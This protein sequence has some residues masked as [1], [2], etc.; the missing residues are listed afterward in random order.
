MEI[1]AFIVL[2]IFAGLAAG[3]LGIGG[4]MIIVPSLAI[5]F[6]YMGIGSHFMVQYASGTSLAI[7]IFTSSI[8]VYKNYRLKRI[9]FPAFKQTIPWILVS[10]IIGAGIARF[11][12]GPI[13]SLFFATMLLFLLI[14]M[15]L[16]NKDHKYNTEILSANININIP[17]KASFFYGLLIGFKSG[18]LGI[19][20]GAIS[21]PY[22]TK[23]KMPIKIASATT[24]AFTLPVAII[25][26][27]CYW[28][29]GMTDKVE[30]IY[31][32]GYIYW[33]AVIAIAPISMLSV[34]FGTKLATYLQ[35]KIIRLMFIVLLIILIT[36]ML[37]YT[38]SLL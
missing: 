31:S 25:G 17:R 37:I 15:L 34:P 21:I 20:G 18:L 32:S 8:A 7:M 10:I 36:K 27:A 13:L 28:L 11:L 1:I 5:I 16:Q 6:G 2:G 3:V 19:G 4:G 35:P 38:L 22:L 33:P 12:P 26:T 29:L 9:Y 30:Q 14:G 23:Y 24:S